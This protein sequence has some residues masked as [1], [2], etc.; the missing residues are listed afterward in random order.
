MKAFSWLSFLIIIWPTL[1]GAE[2]KTLEVGYFPNVTHA[3]ALIA[4]NMSADGRGWFEDR[5]PGVTI[6]WHS[7]NAGPSAMEALFAGVVHLT[8][9]GPNPVLNA[10]IRSKGGIHVVAGAV[11]GGAGLVVPQSSSLSKPLD[12]KGKIIATPQLGNTQDIACRYWLI[13][14]GLKVGLTGGE[15]TLMPTS[16][17]S[18]LPLFLKGR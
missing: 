14:A 6:N 5:L 4:Q 3:Q 17:P 8:Y 18:I 10:Y 7:F 12:F 2:V 15:V 9:V 11:R 13:Q 16:N 1:A